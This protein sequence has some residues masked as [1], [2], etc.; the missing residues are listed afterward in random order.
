MESRPRGLICVFLLALNPSMHGRFVFLMLRSLHCNPIRR[1]LLAF[2]KPDLYPV[3]NDLTWTESIDPLACKISRSTNLRCLNCPVGNTHALRRWLD[4]N[5]P[6]MG[7]AACKTQQAIRENARRSL[8]NAGSNHSIL[9]AID[10]KCP[11]MTP[12]ICI[13]Q[14]DCVD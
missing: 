7:N 6:Q 9:L 2:A 4:R 3:R 5:T 11:S 12:W 13:E 14:M 8:V 10:G 1:F